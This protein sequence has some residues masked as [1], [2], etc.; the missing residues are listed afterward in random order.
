MDGNRVYEVS[1]INE[2]IKALLDGDGALRAVYVRG[3]LSN[4]K[5]YPSG[6]HYFTMKDAAGSLRCVMF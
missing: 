4:Y 6:H 1:E 2:R 5:L 3:E